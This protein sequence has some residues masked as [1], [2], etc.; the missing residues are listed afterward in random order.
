MKYLKCWKKEKKKEHQPKILYAKMF[1]FKTW[2]KNVV[3]Q[4]QQPG[5]EFFGG[6]AVKNQRRHCYNTIQ[7]LAQ[8]LPSAEA[9]NNYNHRGQV[10]TEERSG[11]SRSIGGRFNKQGDLVPR[12]LPQK[13]YPCPSLQVNL[14]K[15]TTSHI[16]QLWSQ[17][18]KKSIHKKTG[19][20]LLG[21]TS[22][23]KATRYSSFTTAL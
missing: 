23:T 2:I 21:F 3:V 4:N 22:G 7:S 6:P 9:K 11:S 16:L 15:T 1:S 8:E 5:G 18:R 13:S 20:H 17:R 19:A 12:L 14:Q 10:K